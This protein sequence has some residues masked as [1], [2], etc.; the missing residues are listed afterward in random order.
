MSHSV[1]VSY[2]CRT[3]AVLVC[4]S[5]YVSVDGAHFNVLHCQR[6]K[7]AEKKEW[8]N[9]E[10]EQLIHEYQNRHELWDMQ[11]INYRNKRRKKEVVAKLAT[12]FK[13]TDAEIVRKLHNL[14][15][16]FNNEARKT[17]DCSEEYKGWESK[18]QHYKSLLFLKDS[19][20]C[21]PA[22]YL[23]HDSVDTSVNYL[24]P[25]DCLTDSNHSDGDMDFNNHIPFPIDN[26]YRTFGEFVATEL[27]AFPE[28]VAK[29]IKVQILQLIIDAHSP[30]NN[31]HPSPM[32]HQ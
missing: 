2:V 13:T 10:T 29:S 24:S 14:R 8:V 6:C 3:V 16:Q 18:W 11:C 26:E 25:M 20:E 32:R 22:C 19:R 4:V 31:H 12:K 21:N 1:C 7:M 17:S 28:Q 30:K 27:N 9:L 15:N 5:L 23:S